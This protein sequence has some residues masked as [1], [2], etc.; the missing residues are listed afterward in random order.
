MWTIRKSK[1]IMNMPYEGTSFRNRMLAGYTSCLFLTLLFSLFAYHATQT[2]WEIF[3][4]ILAVWQ[5]IRLVKWLHLFERVWRVRKHLPALQD[6]IKDLRN[7]DYTQFAY[8]LNRTDYIVF[9]VTATYTIVPFL[10]WRVE[11]RQYPENAYAIPKDLWFELQVYQNYY[12]HKF[13]FQFTDKLK[14]QY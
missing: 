11:D 6:E 8:Q 7:M 2:G 9:G 4:I 12:L 10:N 13:R 14:K 3:W 1:P 5:F